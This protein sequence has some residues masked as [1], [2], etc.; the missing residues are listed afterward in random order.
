MQEKV[1]Q[2]INQ[3]HLSCSAQTRYID[4]TSELGELGK[5]LLKSSS[6]GS[7]PVQPNAAIAEEAGDCLFSLLALMDELHLNAEEAL[8]AVLA[9]YEQRF[10]SKG[11]VDSGR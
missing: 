1:K 5:E 9:K 2:F 3:Y 10:H 11:S 6:Y 7:V 8:Q 4:L